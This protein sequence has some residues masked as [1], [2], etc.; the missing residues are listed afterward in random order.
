MSEFEALPCP[1]CASEPMITT[2]SATGYNHRSQSTVIIAWVTELRC[3]N[4]LQSKANGQASVKS[5]GGN[6]LAQQAAMKDAL[7]KWNRRS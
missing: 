1:F 2:E 4:C 5:S 6:A 3:M 7:R